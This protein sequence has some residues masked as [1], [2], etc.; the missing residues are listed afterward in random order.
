MKKWWENLSEREQLI[1]GGGG[2]IGILLLLYLFVYTP[3]ANA[4]A[5]MKKQVVYQQSIL[6]KVQTIN[7]EIQGMGAGAAAAPFTIDNLQSSLRQIN[8]DP[9]VKKIQQP[10]TNQFLLNLSDADFDTIAGWLGQLSMQYNVQVIQMKLNSVENEPGLVNGT[11]LL[12][13]K[14]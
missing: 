10:Q 14:Q 1:I 9:A 8:L 11:I 5:T 13:V 7:A 12:Q 3:L 2:F 4:V 6:T